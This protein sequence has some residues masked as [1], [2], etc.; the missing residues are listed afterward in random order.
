MAQIQPAPGPV[1][2]GAYFGIVEDAPGTVAQNVFLLLFNPTT[3]GITL[4]PIQ[5]NTSSYTIGVSGTANSFLVTRISAFSGGTI[6]TPS[7]IGRYT[8]SFPDPKTQ[9]V[10]GNPSITAIGNPV[11]ALPPPISNG[12]GSGGTGTVSQ[13]APAL[14]P[15]GQGVA[16]YTAA[17]NTN[18]VWNIIVPFLEF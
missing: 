15:A 9:V 1:I 17:G 11:F 6:A 2:R 10:T 4:N 18:Q 14:V 3:S 8:P 16:F 12:M 5:L 7:T 13:A